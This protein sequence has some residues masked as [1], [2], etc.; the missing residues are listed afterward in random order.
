M[1]SGD[2]SSNSQDLW[3]DEDRPKS[4]YPTLRI[5]SDLPVSLPKRQ[6]VAPPSPPPAPFVEFEQHKGAPRPS[7]FSGI[8]RIH[9][10]QRRQMSEVRRIQRGRNVWRSLLRPSF[11]IWPVLAVVLYHFGPGLSQSAKSYWLKQRQEIIELKDPKARL[12]KEE[13]SAKDSPPRPAR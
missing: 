9:S 12:K 2:G 10:Q 4:S 1:E 11:L 3:Q 6:K 5:F 13:S 7:G 8:F